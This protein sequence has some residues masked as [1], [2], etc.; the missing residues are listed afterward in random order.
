MS[1]DL[2][3]INPKFPHNVG[4]AIRASSCY[5]GGGVFFKTPG[6]EPFYSG[7]ATTNASVFSSRRRS[8]SAPDGRP[9]DASVSPS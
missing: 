1:T 7:D 6:M 2:L 3:L 5:G 8:A 9:S 4:A